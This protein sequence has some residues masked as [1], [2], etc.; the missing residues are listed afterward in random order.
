MPKAGKFRSMAAPQFFDAFNRPVKV[1][2]AGG[3]TEILY[4][5]DGTRLP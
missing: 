4:A 1:Q 2:T 5:P 3:Y